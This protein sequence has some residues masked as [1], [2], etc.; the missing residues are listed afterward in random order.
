MPSHLEMLGKAKRPLH[1]VVEL[2]ASM[3]GQK[4]KGPLHVC[5]PAV[6]DLQ[7]I[8]QYDKMHKSNI[9]EVSKCIACCADLLVHLV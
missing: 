6:A 9:H 8:M 5:P 1:L 4:R 2:V 7:N 3:T